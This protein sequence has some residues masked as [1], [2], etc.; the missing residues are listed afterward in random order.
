MRSEGE[1]GPKPGLH[2]LTKRRLGARH[3]EPPM[4]VGEYAPRRRLYSTVLDGASVGESRGVDSDSLGTQQ[5][6]TVDIPT[7]GLGRT[8]RPFEAPESMCDRL[9]GKTSYWHERGCGTYPL[10]SREDGR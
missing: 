1:L 6:R 8:C 2:K 10:D 4:T 9:P 3:A 7:Q 5:C